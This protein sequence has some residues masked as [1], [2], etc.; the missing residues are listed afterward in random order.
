MITLWRQVEYYNLDMIISVGYRVKSARGVQ[1]RRWATRVLRQYLMQGYVCQ[2]QRL[3]DLST[4]IRVMKRVENKLD[5]AQI[6]AVV[7]Q[8]TR[9]LDLLDD[10]DHQRLQKPQGDTHAYVLTYDE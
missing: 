5:A 4:I 7:Q 2:Q 8:Y 6:L 10:Y 9:S 1:F 3:Q